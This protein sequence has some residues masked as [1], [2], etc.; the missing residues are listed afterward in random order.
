VARNFA[1]KFLGGTKSNLQTRFTGLVRR[2]P[3]M[4]LFLSDFQPQTFDFDNFNMVALTDLRRP[5]DGFRA[6]QL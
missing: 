5:F 3:A 2:T 1:E 4:L 6:P